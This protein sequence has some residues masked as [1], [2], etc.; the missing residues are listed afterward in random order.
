MSH[1]FE[2]SPN[3]LCAIC[4]LS[5][6]LCTKAQE[7][8]NQRAATET[9]SKQAVI[10]GQQI[11]STC[12]VVQLATT[13]QVTLVVT[14]SGQVF[15]WGE[16]CKALGR[17][18]NSAADA[19]QVNLVPALRAHFVAK[20]ACGE[21][22][23]LALLHNFT[24]WSWGENNSGQLGLGH[25]R[26]VEDPRLVEGRLKGRVVIDVLAWKDTSFVAALGGAVFLWGDNTHPVMQ[27]TGIEQASGHY[28][29][30]LPDE[31]A[32]LTHITTPVIVMEKKVYTGEEVEVEQDEDVSIAVDFEGNLHL[33]H[34][35]SNLEVLSASI[36]QEAVS[37][38][39]QEN[40]DLRDR[41][42]ELQNKYDYI[43]YNQED[44]PAEWAKS[45]DLKTLEVEMK[46]LRGLLHVS[47]ANSAQ[48]Q[49]RIEEI[50]KSQKMLKEDKVKWSAEQEQ[51]WGQLKQQYSTVEETTD[52]VATGDLLS[53]AMQS[54]R[55]D[56]E[57][58]KLEVE[59]K[60]RR[61]QLA[62]NQAQEEIL[63]AQLNIHN[64][65][66]FIVRKHIA[67]QGF[68]YGT[69]NEQHRIDE[70]LEIQEEVNGLRL[71]TALQPPL[72]RDQVQTIAADLTIVRTRLQN[73]T[74]PA[75]SA[76]FEAVEKTRNML[77]AHI[78]L[79]GILVFVKE[80]DPERRMT[81]EE[82]VLEDFSWG[83]SHNSRTP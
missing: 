70:L 40:A 41:I 54:S 16:D 49:S 58:A 33:Y 6:R 18:V 31:A 20:V 68:T 50:I 63:K 77:L 62:A 17:K 65:M 11:P 9:L 30:F 82:Q 7:K 19:H 13:A 42:R 36:S 76:L 10:F 3:G 72:S 26:E 59:I 64:G 23:I 1:L 37:S 83:P 61:E 71:I 8:R 57:M 73:L 79:L 51:R 74:Y 46:R 53:I 81:V 4:G 38:M 48:L 29:H 5:L 22:H 69:D 45:D 44:M 60:Q 78:R 80:I 27:D 67:Y 21:S 47:E 35:K 43:D 28:G 25:S 34:S 39:T 56:E 2:Q 24:V 14:S 52:L 75:S 15:T 66:K 12:Q 32:R 55:A